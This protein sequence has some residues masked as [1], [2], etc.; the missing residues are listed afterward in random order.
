MMQ[1]MPTRF[2]GQGHKLVALAKA[3][4]MEQSAVSGAALPQAHIWARLRKSAI[5]RVKQR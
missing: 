2:G 3:V 4:I 5:Q 1:P